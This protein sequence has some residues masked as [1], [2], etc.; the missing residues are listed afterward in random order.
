MCFLYEK[1]SFDVN[2][3]KILMQIVIAL[4]TELSFWSITCNKWNITFIPC[5][6]NFLS[7]L[8]SLILIVCEMYT[9]MFNKNQKKRCQ[10]IY[11]DV[12]FVRL[13][14]LTDIFTE[15]SCYSNYDSSVSYSSCIWKKIYLYKKVYFLVVKKYF[16]IENKKK[17]VHWCYI[18]YCNML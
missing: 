6:L 8:R 18:L 16:C 1:L 10:S 7:P 14:I 15:Q 5:E 13:T 4:S 11:V 12:W 3:L 17:L 9:I 2:L